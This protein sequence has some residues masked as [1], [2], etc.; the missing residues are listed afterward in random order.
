MEELVLWTSL[1]TM[2]QCIIITLLPPQ[3]KKNKQTNKQTKKDFSFQKWH[4]RMCHCLAFRRFVRFS[5]NI[6]LTV[7]RSFV[8]KLNSLASIYGA[9]DFFKDRKCGGVPKV[10]NFKFLI[11]CVH[12][13]EITNRT[14][15]ISP[16][17][18]SISVNMVKIWI[19]I[20]N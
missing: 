16:V 17:F 12:A 9:F 20:Y 14:F 4:N 7:P 15:L 6:I 3:K 13:S 8:F 5:W 19:N 18:Y 11:P 1:M 2:H 10:F